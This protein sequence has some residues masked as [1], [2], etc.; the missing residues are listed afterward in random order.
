MPIQERPETSSDL[1]GV[2]KHLIMIVVATVTMVAIFTAILLSIEKTGDGTVAP[3]PSS[4]S[5]FDGGQSAAAVPD[6]EASQG[7]DPESEVAA[8]SGRQVAVF[9]GDSYTSGVGGSAEGSGFAERVGQQQNWAVWNLGRPG[10]GYLATATSPRCG[11][12]VCPDYSGMISLVKTYA[13]DIVVVSGGRNDLLL[14]D[15]TQIAA[16][17]E[18]FLLAL[19]AELPDVRIIVTSPLWDDDA[20]PARLVTLTEVVRVQARAAGAE[21]LDLGQPLEGHPELLAP[22][23][24]HPNDAG[25]AVLADTILDRLAS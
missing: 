12:T 20:V 19:R 8:A 3:T 14:P 4:R 1:R 24:V 2:T 23:G 10:T 7:S 25:Y 15:D 6:A 13:P 11:G 16:A 9:V 17:V 21:F 5:I 18:R 22:D